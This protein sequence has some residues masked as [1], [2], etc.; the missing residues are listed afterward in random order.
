MHQSPSLFRGV[1]VQWLKMPKNVQP[2]LFR[3]LCGEQKGP[4]HVEK[5][6]LRNC[7]TLI[8]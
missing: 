6:A 7:F 1:M 4:I 8:L 2:T 5:D 3:S